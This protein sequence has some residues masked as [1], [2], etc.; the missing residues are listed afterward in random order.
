MASNDHRNMST[1]AVSRMPCVAA[2]MRGFSSILA[3]YAQFSKG[4]RPTALSPCMR[5]SRITTPM[6]W[7]V[8]PPHQLWS[9]DIGVLAAR[10]QITLP[11]SRGP[12]LGFQTWIFCAFSEEEW[13]ASSSS[14]ISTGCPEPNEAVQV[15]HDGIAL[16]PY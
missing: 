1:S 8:R 13:W 4:Q 9:F 15:R 16:L 2:H 14:M 10:I 7:A 11:S 12:F 3:R 5:S 6:F